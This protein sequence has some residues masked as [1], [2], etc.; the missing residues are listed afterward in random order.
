MPAAPNFS[1]FVRAAFHRRPYL[2]GMGSVPWNKWALLGALIL[3]FGNPGFWLLG[4]GGELLYL[5][6]MAT[7]PRFRT[8]VRAQRLQTERESAEARVGRWLRELGSEQ[9]QRFKTL[10]EKCLEVRR[11]TETIQ[12]SSLASLDEARWQSLDQLLWLFLRLQVSLEL[13]SRQL[14]GTD[15]AALEGEVTA[16]EQELAGA[17]KLPER[18]RR[19]KEALLELKKK[20]VENLQRA[21]EARQILIAELQRIEQQVELLREEATISRSPEALSARIDSVTSSLDDTNS[22]MRQHQDILSELGADEASPPPRLLE[23][24]RQSS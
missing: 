14:A 24:V 1:D 4:L 22:W 17:D 7:N 19:S 23:R 8:L 9:Q 12:S 3:G 5:Y 10:H 11:I 18:L 20:R 6:L 16:L 13:V 2:R 15:R 21:S